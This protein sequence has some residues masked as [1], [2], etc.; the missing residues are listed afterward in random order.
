M[1]RADAGPGDCTP[2]AQPHE[3]AERCPSFDTCFVA[4]GGG[5]LYYRVDD[6]RFD[7]VG[8]EC[9]MA[10]QTLG[11]YC[12]QRGEFAPGKGGDGGCAQASAP[13]P[14]ALPWLAAAALVSVG[15]RRRRRRG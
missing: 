8:L 14:A 3:C 5:Q 10:S 9:A 15:L 6:Q 12:C 2:S 7:C 13:R 1:G 11:D 4:T